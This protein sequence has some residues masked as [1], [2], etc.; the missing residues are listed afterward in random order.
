[1]KTVQHLG[2]KDAKRLVGKWVEHE[3]SDA[4]FDDPYKLISSL[5]DYMYEHGFEIV[6]ESNFWNT[7][8]PRSKE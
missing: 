2:L 5:F 4:H 3:Y 7:I 1:M 6:I 8:F